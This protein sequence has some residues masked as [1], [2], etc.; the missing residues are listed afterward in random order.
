MTVSGTRASAQAIVLYN[1]GDSS[2]EGQW[3]RDLK[4]GYGCF[5][6]RS[7]AEY[8]GQFYEG[9]MHG[10]GTYTYADGQRYLGEF[11]RGLKHG[12][13]THHYTNEDKWDGVW[14]ADEPHVPGFFICAGSERKIEAREADG[15]PAEGPSEPTRA[16]R[17]RT[18]TRGTRARE[19]ADAHMRTRI[20]RGGA[21][22]ITHGLR[23]R[24]RRQVSRGRR[25]RRG[26]RLWL[27]SSSPQAPLRACEAVPRPAWDGLR[28]RAAGSAARASDGA[29]R[30]L[31]SSES[32]AV[33]GQSSPPESPLATKILND[34]AAFL[35]V[36]SRQ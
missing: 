23:R 8:T 19:G 17:T 4:H 13:G 20:P 1:G 35:G 22:P 18:C 3:V 29:G 32:P 14:V 15:W 36:K 26:H 30:H 10:Q 12:F 16:Q 33:S 34:T 24:C 9:K 21:M 31:G 28:R 25:G 7:G 11:D 6:F 27:R 2:Y 5:R